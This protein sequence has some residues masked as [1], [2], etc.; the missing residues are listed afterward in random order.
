MRRDDCA[1]ASVH[2]LAIPEARTCPAG[3]LTL[4]QERLRALGAHAVFFDGAAIT[5]QTVADT[6]G[7][8]PWTAASA[9]L[10]ALAD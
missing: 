2:V 6:R 4:S 8:R 7:K 1:K 5:V 3:G 9:Q 10:D